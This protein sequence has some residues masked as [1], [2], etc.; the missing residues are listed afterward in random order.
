[1]QLYIT[2]FFTLIKFY[3]NIII[4]TLR[5]NPTLSVKLFTVSLIVLNDIVLDVCDITAEDI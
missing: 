1:M 3:V 5:N 2:S 4:S